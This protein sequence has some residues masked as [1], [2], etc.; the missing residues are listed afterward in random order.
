MGPF[1]LIST[2]KCE[3]RKTDMIKVIE[4]IPSDV[5][6]PFINRRLVEDRQSSPWS[7]VVTL[8]YM[9]ASTVTPA[10]T[11]HTFKLALLLSLA[12]CSSSKV[13][14]YVSIS[15]SVYSLGVSANPRPFKS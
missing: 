12:S 10:G 14:C 4:T 5:L 2:D 13:S 3:S 9:F 15:V 6:S 8:A 1:L 11:F 7:L